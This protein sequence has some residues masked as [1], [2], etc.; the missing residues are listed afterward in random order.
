MGFIPTLIADYM[1]SNPAKSNDEKASPASWV[2]PTHQRRSR[3]NRD[4]LLKAGESVFAMHG[5]A[6]SHVSDIARKAGCSIGSFYR[7]FKDKEALFLALQGEFHDRARVYIDKLFSHPTSDKAPLTEVCFRL[8]ESVASRTLKNK[9]Y[10]RALFEISLRGN[11]V[12]GRMRE[13]ERYQAECLKQLFSRRGHG[14]LRRDFVPAVSA[15]LRMISGN[16]LSMMLHGAGPFEHNDYASNCEFT[17]ILMAVAGIPV[18]E[19]VLKRIKAA[20]DR[21]QK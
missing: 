9:G 12:W 16:Q 1:S 14:A 8:F 6:D 7:R 15:T 4:R 3:L 21:G 18:D 19:K 17:R 11:D 5:F 10:Y 20:R 13:L 2:F